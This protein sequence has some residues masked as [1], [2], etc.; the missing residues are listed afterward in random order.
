[1]HRNPK[2]IILLT[3]RVLGDLLIC[4][5]SMDFMGQKTFATTHG[6]CDI[7]EQRMPFSK[8]RKRKKKKVGVV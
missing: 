6:E 4:H 7:L 8:E 3:T 2:T 1:M 5:L